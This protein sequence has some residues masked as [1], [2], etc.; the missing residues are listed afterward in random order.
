[1]TT[2]FGFVAYAAEG[3]ANKFASE[4]TRHGLTERGFT[5]AGRP[6]KAENRTLEVTLQ[7]KHRDVFDNPV[8]DL[9][10]AEM[11][12]VEHCARGINVKHVLGRLVPGQRDHPL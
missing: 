1:M 11:I 5:G 7:G 2:N 8:L 3:D 6:R 9:L 12:R 4:R 10:E